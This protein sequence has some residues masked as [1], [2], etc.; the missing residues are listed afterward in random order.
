M[1]RPSAGLANQ[2]QLNPATHQEAACRESFIDL[3]KKYNIS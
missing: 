2:P 3:D 1:H